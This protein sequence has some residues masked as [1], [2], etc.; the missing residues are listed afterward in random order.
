MVIG[1]RHAMGV[2]A[3]IT[4]HLRRAITYFT[5]QGVSSKFLP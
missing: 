5:H 1:N 3:E 4:Q 2:A